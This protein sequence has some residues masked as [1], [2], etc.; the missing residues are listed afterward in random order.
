VAIAL[1]VAAI[2]WW[3]LRGRRP[4]ASLVT[5]AVVVVVAIATTVLTV[6]VGHSGAE[7]TWAGSDGRVQ[8]AGTATVDREYTMEQ[9]ARHGDAVSCWTVVEGDVYDV[10]TWIGRHPG[11]AAN[12]EQLCGRDGTDTF[13]GQHGEAQRPSAALAD[14]RVGT[15]VD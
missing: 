9:V 2:A 8:Q 12:I 3:V 6:L 5:G 4:V 10:T 14:H 1:W 15:L 7:A 13:R 11:G